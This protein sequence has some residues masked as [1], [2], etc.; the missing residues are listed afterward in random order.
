MSKARLKTSK[1]AIILDY[2]QPAENYFSYELAKKDTLSK[3]ALLGAI[4]QVEMPDGQRVETTAQTLAAVGIG[5][6]SLDSGDLSGLMGSILACDPDRFKILDG[7]PDVMQSNH[8]KFDELDITFDNSD[9]DIY[10]NTLWVKDVQEK[11]RMQAHIEDIKRFARI[12][13][14]PV[15]DESF[16]LT[17]AEGGI[18]WFLGAILLSLSIN[19]GKFEPSIPEPLSDSPS[20]SDT[21][22]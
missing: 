7:A 9:N 10:L 6:K 19:Q 20:T 21:T 15:T 3:L 2:N 17:V 14:K 22:S 4:S 11:G 16:S 18:G 8:F 13:G 5:R 12:D 1:G